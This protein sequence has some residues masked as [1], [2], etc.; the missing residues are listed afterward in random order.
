MGAVANSG[1]I[2]L[3]GLDASQLGTVATTTAGTQLTG[4]KAGSTWTVSGAGNT[5]A[6]SADNLSGAPFTGTGSLIQFDGASGSIAFAEGSTLT[7]D[8]TSV[9]DA[10][11]TAGGTL[12]ILL[13]N[14]TITAELA[15][16]KTHITSNPL[17][18][19]LGFGIVDADGGNIV[20]S[21]DTD[22]IYVASVDGTGSADAPVKNQE[23]NFYQAVI[24]NEDLYVESDGTMV[25]KNLT[26]PGSGAGQQGTGNLIVTNTADN[27]GSIELQNNLFDG[28]TGVDTGFAGDIIAQQGVLQLDGTAM[29]KPC[30]LTRR[31][32]EPRRPSALAET[33]RPKRWQL[34]P[35]EARWTSHFRHAHPHGGPR[36]PWAT[37]PS[38]AA[39]R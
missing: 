34:A 16:L 2:A 23:L 28:P 27:K 35:T 18:S 11:K 9:A 33:P 30:G 32:P 6:V 7:L 38:P 25:I 10:M 20:I 37:P 17:F 5:L 22:L 12:E 26:A 3:G 8:L 29:W 21:G 24:V 15:A 4:L 14:G 36:Q 39:A 13:T 1:N 31:M 19:A